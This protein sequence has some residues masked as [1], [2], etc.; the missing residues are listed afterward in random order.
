MF[1][2]CGPPG[3]GPPLAGRLATA[4]ARRPKQLPVLPS[5]ADCVGGCPPRK[6][7]GSTPVQGFGMKDHCLCQH[8]TAR[9]VRGAQVLYG[10]DARRRYEVYAPTGEMLSTRLLEP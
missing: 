4:T 10:N 5:G 3:C 2:T 6:E 7:L 8:V 1:P 9:I